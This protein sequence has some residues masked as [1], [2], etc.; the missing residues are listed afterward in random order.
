M[1]VSLTVS[2]NRINLHSMVAIVDQVASRSF[3]ET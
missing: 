2:V 3:V 1:V